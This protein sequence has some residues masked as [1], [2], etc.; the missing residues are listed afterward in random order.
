MGNEYCDDRLRDLILN[1]KHVSEVAVEPLGPSLDSRLCIHELRGDPDPIAKPAHTAFDDITH[2][3]LPAYLTHVYCPAF[4]AKRGIARDDRQVREIRQAVDDVLGD[5]VAEIFLRCVTAE[6]R[7]RQDCDRGYVQALRRVR[8]QAGLFARADGHPEKITTARHGFDDAVLRIAQG[9][10]YVADATTQRIF[11]DEY[12]R[13]ECLHEF[14]FAD[15]AIGVLDQEA[16]NL[17]TL[18]PQLELLLAA[19]HTAACHIEGKALEPEQL[20]AFGMD[21]HLGRFQHFFSIFSAAFRD[22]TAQFGVQSLQSQL[23]R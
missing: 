10:T 11:G 17:E 2:A 19:S 9:D 4:V 14:V 13:P 7:E 8:R 21:R 23:P 16:Q 20:A 18:G 22:R 1:G 12:A 5:P 3:Q 6:V 15:E